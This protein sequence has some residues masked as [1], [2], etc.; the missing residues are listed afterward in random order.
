M[1]RESYQ[2]AEGNGDND[3]GDNG[4]GGELVLAEVASKRLGDDCERKHSEST[5]D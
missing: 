3:G 2:E 4:D 1:G 5:K